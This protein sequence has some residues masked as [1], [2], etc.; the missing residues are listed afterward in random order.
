LSLISLLLVPILL[1]WLGWTLWHRVRPA[2]QEQVPG[3]DLALALTQVTHI[4]V[5]L[6]FLL[7]S[8]SI[9]DASTPLNDRILS[10]IYIPEMI[11]FSSAMAWLWNWLNGRLTVL[12]WVLLVFC[13]VLIAF[14][15]KDGYA[16][17]NQLGRE[18]QGFAHRGISDSP[19]I[20]TIRSSPPIIIYSNKPGAIFL[21]TGKPAYVTPTPM[22]PVTGKAR[23]NFNDDLVHMQ[24]RVRDGEAILVLFGLRNSQ[25]PDEINLFDTLSDDLR[26]LTDY[27]DILIFGISP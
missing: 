9:F 26:I 25:D 23:S 1:A 5:Y 12:R 16:A 14:S 27:G 20:Q 4:F 21:L 19:A 17:V 2:K 3:G 15:A 24:Q 10:V 22:D 11:L 18:G 6:G 13:L 7:I 8:I